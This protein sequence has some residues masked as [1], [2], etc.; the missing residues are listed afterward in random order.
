ML[1]RRYV[2]ISILV[3]TYILQYIYTY[4]LY[5]IHEYNNIFNIKYNVSIFNIDKS[6]II[7]NV[8]YLNYQYNYI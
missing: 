1:I 3:M 5:L 4:M 8:Y 2:H 7:S 6:Y